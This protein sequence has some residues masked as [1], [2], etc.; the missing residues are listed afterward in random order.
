[1]SLWQRL[2]DMRIQTKIVLLVYSVLISSLI[3][4][5]YMNKQ[6]FQENSIQGIINKSRA[7]TLQAENTR[8]YMS[9]LRTD[10]KAFDDAKLFQEVKDF[11]EG[12]EF[13][14]QE[15]RIKAIRETS[16]YWTI[17]IV[18]SWSTANIEAKE[19]GFKFRVPKVQARN[20]KNEATPLEVSMLDVLKQENREEYWIEDKEANVLR[21]MRPIRLTKDCLVCHGTINDDIDHD[22]ID[23]VGIKM[24]GWKEGE[25]HGAFEI[26]ADL[27]PMQSA[28]QDNLYRSILIILALLVVSTAAIL[29]ITR[30]I[31]TPL[32]SAVNIAESMAAGNLNVQ[33]N[34][35]NNDEVGKMLQAMQA[36]YEK[37]REIIV[38]VNQVSLEVS[39]KNEQTNVLVKHLR[40]GATEQASSLEEALVSVR[41]MVDTIRSNSDHAVRTEHMS[42]QTASDAQLTGQSV[43]KTV[44][45]ILSINERISDIESIAK[46][47]NLLAL[48][49]SLEAV[50]AGEHG[51]GFEIVANEVQRLAERSQQAAADIV[52]LS[53]DS[54]NSAQQSGDM[55][56]ALLPN[57]DETSKLVREIAD[58]SEDQ[59]DSSQQIS[60]ALQ[61]LEQI[62][63]QNSSIAVELETAST[64]MQSLVEQLQG[65]MRFFHVDEQDAL[66]V[67]AI[68]N[69]DTTMDPA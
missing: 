19:A 33:F 48:N 56:D 58:A 68:E 10:K 49:A 50:R 29:V 52:K 60:V 20:P 27:T 17:P 11:L 14:T 5:F 26:I 61:Q 18:S 38:Q 32:K 51:K 45:G 21:Y 59:R 25:I 1:M 9:D 67:V 44:S 34:Q 57:I 62:A 65:L 53:R 15:E 28:I 8:R 54:A 23:P 46:K 40:Q 2:R 16:F 39:A 47:T 43:S 63:V 42:T 35:S 13:E 37:L 69:D 3:I 24:E 7:I 66:D 30:S 22:G 55:L 41:H 12:K 31:S 4:L 64:Y 36:M 6:S